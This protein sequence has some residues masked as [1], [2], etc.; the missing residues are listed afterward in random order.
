MSLLIVFGVSA[1]ASAFQ[2]NLSGNLNQPSAHVITIG[3]DRATVDNVAGFAAGDTILIIQMQGV[4]LLLSPYG[5]VQGK[6]GEPGMHEFMIIDAINGGNEIVFKRNTL[7]TYAPEGNIQIVRVPYYNTA[8]VTGKLFSNPWNQTTKKGGVLAL[9]IGRTLK[10]NAD[11]DLSGSGFL[12]GKDAIGDAV[13]LPSGLD[14]YAESFTNAGRKGEGVANYTEFN[15]PL[16]PNYAKG[17][18]N[19]WTGGGGG[20][21]RYAGGAGGSNRGAGGDGGLED[22]F[23]S[24][25]PAIGGVKAFHTSLPD[26]LFFWWRWWG[27]DFSHRIST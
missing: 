9:I 12:G 3:P 20:N 8:T 14:Y 1:P 27:I 2:K 6:Y 16:L 26:R 21:G 10:L 13:C 17:I 5:S 22:C 11:I 19:N 15:Q 7:K 18:G 25:S 4:K 23:P 24:G